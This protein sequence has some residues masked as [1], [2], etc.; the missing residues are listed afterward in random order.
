VR[1]LRAQP[2]KNLV[3]I[4][5]IFG[6]FMDILDVTVVNVALHSMAE[7]FDVGDSTI[8]WVVIGYILSLAVWIPAS[9][10]IGDRYGTKRTFMFA[11]V[12]FTGASALCGAAWSIESLIAFRVLQGVGGG[13]L[14]PVGMAMLFR[15]FPPAER[16]RA[17]A[18]LAIPTVLAPAVGPVFG[19]IVTTHASWRWIF[20]V[21]LP[22]GV[23]A[24]VFTAVFIKEHKE[25]TAG[26]FDVGGFV[27]SGAGL[28]LVLYALSRAPIAG[29][30]STEVIGTAVVG[31][32]AF[33]LLVVVELR[34]AEPMLDLRLYR[35]RLFRTSNIVSF[36]MIGSFLGVLFLLP[37]YLQGLR[38]LSPQDSGLTTFPQ[39]IG[40][41][42]VA[43][44]VGAKLYP[45]LGPRRLLI[46]GLSILA[47]GNGVFF[48][49]GPDTNLWLIRAV[50][51]F[52]GWGMGF[53]FIPMQTISFATIAPQDTGRASSLSSTVRQVGSAVGVAVLATVLAARTRHHVGNIGGAVTEAAAAQ[54]RLD[55]FHDAF[56]AS[57]VIAAIGIVA[58]C[59]VRDADAHIAAGTHR[60]PEPLQAE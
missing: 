22:I 1:W 20:Y 36:M 28:A 41:M 51:F 32:L 6:V 29:W 40:V 10:W 43:R 8:E 15:A 37:L 42:F 17:S 49:I 12:M 57:V 33:A 38:G 21:N 60:A 11:L 2:Y 44:F 46:T 34:V 14:A 50:M 35:D 7:E 39:A 54:A 5:F 31:V 58:A 47:L 52:R 13:M 27:L 4:A 25:P 53:A 19:G 45:K 26:G 55:G 16:A 30:G 48:W 24:F 18:V 3:A 9:G 56:F 59:F 23:L